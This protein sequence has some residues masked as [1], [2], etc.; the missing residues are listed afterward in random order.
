M[1][2]EELKSVIAEVRE[3]MKDAFVSGVEG[4]AAK[5]YL[6]YTNQQGDA[7]YFFIGKRVGR[8]NFSLLI[9]VESIGLIAVNDTLV[10][11]QAML[12]TYGLQLTQ[13]AIICDEHYNHPM[14]TRLRDMTH[15]ILGIDGIRRLW[16]T[17][18]DRRPDAESED[19]KS[20]SNKTQP[21]PSRRG[22][23]LRRV[24]AK[25]STPTS[26]RR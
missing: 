12:Q 6:P 22:P 19:S 13:E 14:Q 25:G 15:A 11:L 4:E 7:L 8:N 2:Q 24:R 9:P 10:R 20:L 21:S 3:F 23:G 18:Y 17:E 5:V 26:K 1:N 16:K